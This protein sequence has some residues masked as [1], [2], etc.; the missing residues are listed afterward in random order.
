[1][2]T[3]S[4]SISRRIISKLIYS[5]GFFFLCICLKWVQ[6]SANQVILKFSQ[7]QTIIKKKLQ[8]THLTEVWEVSVLPLYDVMS[9]D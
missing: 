7:I 4:S 8:K 9:G 5:E 6:E 1:M 3:S 2:P